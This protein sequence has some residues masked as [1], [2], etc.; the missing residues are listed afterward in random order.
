MRYISYDMYNHIE[1]ST[2]VLS[3]VWHKHLGVIPNIPDGVRHVLNM[4]S[5]DEISFDVYKEVD[6]KVCD[7]WNKIVSMKYVYVPEHHTYYEINVSTDDGDATIKHVTGKSAGETELSNRKLRGLHINDE[8]DINYEAPSVVPYEYD[9]D[10][11]TLLPGQTEPYKATVLYR[12]VYDTDPPDLA[13]KRNALL[14]CTVYWRIN[15]LI[16]T[17][18]MWTNI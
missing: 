18:V 9:T 17:L 8:T 1:K 3:T 16:G 15:V 13:A 4:N 2:V 11:S 14:S 7:L 12:P 10:D 5:F 6:G